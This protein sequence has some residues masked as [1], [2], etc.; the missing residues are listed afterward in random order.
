MLKRPFISEK[1]MSLTSAGFYTFVVGK[2]TTKGQI[3]K[4]VK[5]KFSVDILSVKMINLPKKIKLQKTRKG[6]FKTRGLKKAVVKIKKGQKIAL[7]ENL[8]KEE[9]FEKAQD[10]DV[11]VKTAEGEEITTV[12][13]KKSLLRGTKVKIEKK[14]EK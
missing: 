13:E 5:D 12:K 9:S 10:G 1:S 6:Y 7:F 11:V 14:G 4:L 2:N 3:E 8:G